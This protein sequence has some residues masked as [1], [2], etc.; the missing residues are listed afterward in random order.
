MPRVLL[1]SPLPIEIGPLLDG[2]ELVGGDR[3]LSRDELLGAVA[4]ADGLVCLIGDRIDDELLARAPRLRVVANYAV[5]LDN[6]DLAA[7]ARR[8]VAVTHTPDVLTEAT[9]DLAFALLLAAARRVIEGD[10]LVRGG[11]WTGWEPWQILGAE[12]HGATLAIVGMGR[13]GRAV[14]RR[15]RGFDM[16]VI[17]VTSREGSVDEVLP[18]ADFVSIHCPLTAATRGLIDARRL[19][20]MKPTAVLVNTARGPIIDEDALVRALAAGRPAAAGLDVYAAEPQVPE[21]LRRS[22]RVVLL[23]HLGS[24][25]VGARTRMAELCAT[26]VRDVLAGRRPPNLVTNA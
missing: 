24:A 21:T 3:R 19:A 18:Q 13:I 8:G 25:T 4:D 11:G 12:V 17:G 15:A 6:I 5:G 9:A 20:L 14:A 10:A 7:A 2:H 23:P 1:T 26:G 16:R 22:P